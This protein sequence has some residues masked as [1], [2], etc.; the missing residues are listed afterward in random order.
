MGARKDN[1]EGER[2]WVA[3]LTMEKVGLVG[4]MEYVSEKLIV[5]YTGEEKL[6]RSVVRRQRD[7][8][9]RATPSAHL[10]SIASSEGGREP[11]GNSAG[12]RRRRGGPMPSRRF[13]ARTTCS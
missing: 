1:S 5:E 9:V 11:P 4:Q 7:R 2:I 6:L 8:E 13:V 10:R 12:P 3:C